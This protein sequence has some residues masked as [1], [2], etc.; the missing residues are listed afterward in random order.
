MIVS[1]IESGLV[2]RQQFLVIIRRKKVR[3]Q[4]SA[5][6]THFDFD[7]ILYLCVCEI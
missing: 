4:I 1:K 3:A 7:F 2:E 5:V 6:L